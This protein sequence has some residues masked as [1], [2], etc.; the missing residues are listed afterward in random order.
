MN[1]KR[2]SRLCK[3]VF[4]CLLTV[5]LFYYFFQTIDFSLFL[6]SL[7]TI[8]WGW[9]GVAALCYL[10]TY[11][12]RGYRI[13]YLT[14]HCSALTYSK[15]L[16]LTF[17]HQ[18][19]GRIIPFKV[20]D[21]SLVYLLK[22]RGNVGMPEGSAVL[23]L[24]RLFD[25][26]IILVSFLICNLAVRVP[27]FSSYI[28]LGILALLLGGLLVTPWLIQKITDW[29]KHHH[30]FNKNL[31]KKGSDAFSQIRTLLLQAVVSG[32]RFFMLMGN[33]LL[34]WFFVYLSMHFI[35]VAFG[36]SFLLSETIVASFLASA[37]AFLPINGI[38][39]FGAVETGWVIG[40]TA[41]G[42]N[43]AVALSSGMISNIMSFVVIC[44][45]GLYSFLERKEISVCTK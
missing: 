13:F 12:I 22:S 36:Q 2:I 32:R 19:Y 11:P 6:S 28:I 17:R 3:I 31:I 9:V 33:S 7:Y 38:G 45:M 1:K 15:T 41:L 27:L 21:L 23:L 43:Q 5:F 10:C 24:L 42:M 37:A 20:G 35:V 14:K 40:F 34:L 16:L 29:L 44:L 25:G 30:Y 18:F 4:S 39:G 26:F 8:S